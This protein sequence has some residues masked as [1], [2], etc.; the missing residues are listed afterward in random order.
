MYNE[1]QLLCFSHYLHSLSPSCLLLKLNPA[2]GPDDGIWA[3]ACLNPGLYGPRIGKASWHWHQ[4]LQF[5]RSENIIRIQRS[6][7]WYWRDRDNQ[8][9]N[10][11]NISQKISLCDIFESTSVPTARWGWRV[12]NGTIRCERTDWGLTRGD[13]WSECHDKLGCLNSPFQQKFYLQTP[14]KYIRNLKVLFPIA[15]SERRLWLNQE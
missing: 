14:P 2:V 15:D 9:S 1:E 4:H 3:S 10:Q 5:L 7:H 13:K 11:I 12:I 8:S 6:I